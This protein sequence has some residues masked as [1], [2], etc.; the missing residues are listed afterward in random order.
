MRCSGLE[1]RLKD[2]S[3]VSRIA[4]TYIG[5][6]LK[7]FGENCSWHKHNRCFNSAQFKAALAYC[8]HKRV[9]ADYD[10]I[11]VLEMLQ[12]QKEHMWPPMFRLYRE[13]IMFPTHAARLNSNHKTVANDRF[14]RG[15]Y[16][17]ERRM[18]NQRR[19]QLSLAYIDRLAIEVRN[20]IREAAHA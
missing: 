12:N 10:A 3:T 8:V 20:T 1:T 19:I 2:E 17:I 13:Q 5:D 14:C 15:V 7:H 6:I 18:K 9:I 4:D 11:A 16:T